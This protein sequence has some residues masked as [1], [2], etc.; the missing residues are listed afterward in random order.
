[1][2]KK[3]E[4]ISKSS[5]SSVVDLPPVFRTPVRSDLI[6]FVHKNVALNKRQ[7]Y[8]VNPNAGKNYSAE[9]WGTG[10]AVARVARIKGSGTRR[11]GQ[12]AFANFC[13]GGHMAHPTNV[14]RR[15]QRKTPL[16]MRRLVT[17]MGISASAVAPI[18]ESR[19]HRISGLKSIPLV[20][21][22]EMLQDVKKTKDAVKF[23]V[24]LGL[25]EEMDKTKEVF[26]KSGKG[27]M[28]NRRYKVKKGPLIVYD[29]EI[30]TKAFRNVQ[31]V[32]MCRVDDLNVLE[33]CPGGQP[34][35]LVIWMKDAFV[36]LHDLF[37][38]LENE[39]NLKAGF[40]LTEGIASGD[41]I[42]RIF[43]SCE[44]QAFIDEPCLIDKPKLV[45]NVKEI[46]KLNPYLSLI[47]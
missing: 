37:G 36:K 23:L 27:K 3:I 38:D 32:D 31:G 25:T 28:R 47:N 26:I 9:G 43:H 6:S 34:G 29:K 35:R 42:E 30:C 20:V 13:R 1:M 39:A 19:G 17:A 18:V 5:T 15:W 12:G 44:V 11:A 4:I 21:D 14:R 33:L 24:E 10:R 7:P 2:Q 16:N 46:E 22:N 40:L 45:K 41:D 8:A